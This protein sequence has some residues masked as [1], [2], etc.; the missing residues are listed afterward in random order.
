MMTQDSQPSPRPESPDSGSVSAPGS[1]PH[2]TSV[3]APGPGSSG[4]RGSGLFF[5]SLRGV[6]RPWRAIDLAIILG[7]FLVTI[8]IAVPGILGYRGVSPIDEITHFDYAYKLAVDHHIPAAVEPLSD[9]ALSEW[10]CRP[11]G[12]TSEELCD[13]AETGEADT[14]EFP[15]VGLNYNGFHPPLYYFITGWIGRA[16]SA[17]TP[18]TLF[19]AMRVGSAVWLAAGLSAC[20]L[21]VSRHS[22][23]ALGLAA[24]ALIGS[25]PAVSA[26]AFIVSPDSTAAL[27]GAAALFVAL[28][29][30][31]PILAAGLLAFVIA[32]TKLLLAIG[33]LCVSGV[34]FLT[35]P[36]RAQ[37]RGRWALVLPSALAGTA[38]SALISRLLTRWAGPSLPN[39]ILGVS[40]RPAEGEFVR[41]ILNMIGQNASLARPY[42][43]PDDLDSP[44][45]QLVTNLFV[46]LV[47]AAPILALA[48]RR[49][50]MVVA[51][52]SLLAGMLFT[53]VVIQIRELLTHG[54]YFPIIVSRYSIVFLPF[55]LALALLALRDRE[56]T[57]P[58]A[59]TAGGIGVLL[60]AL[61]AVGL[62]HH[63]L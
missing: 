18:L 8:G 1:A 25:T 55:A 34:L 22:S 36:W 16:L 51:G 5:A 61:H 11:S 24:A 50:P 14:E 45:T 31:P 30:S 32:S 17:L 10:A 4:E 3:S 47:L 63:L 41:P 27:A 26:F 52:L 40:T 62:V 57:V 42:W 23:R 9:E 33:I 21:V 12:W 6:S 28:A 44:F 56:K 38:A 43:F 19:A 37:D 46:P 54:L 15:A 53:P 7:I 49:W 58:V 2:S 39:P 59:L 20:Y 35:A 48:R 13:L 60:L 29:A